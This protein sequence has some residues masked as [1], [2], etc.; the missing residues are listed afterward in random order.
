MMDDRRAEIGAIIREYDAQGWHR[1]GT[2]VDEASAQW[3]ADRVTSLGATPAF[4]SFTFE[5]VDPLPGYV[6]IDG[7]REEGTPA[8]D[9]TFTGGEGISG[10]IGPV[11]SDAEIALVPTPPGPERFGELYAARRS[12]LHRA[13]VAPTMGGMPGLGLINAP[14]FREPF[15]PPVLE[16]SSEAA[17]WLAAAAARGAT[18]HMVAAATRQHAEA[19]NVTA[20]VRGRDTSLA[21]LVAMTP[22]SGWWACASERGGGIACWLEVLRASCADDLDRT[23][24]FVA[25]SGHE[26]GHLGLKSFLGARPSLTR[27]AFATIHLGANIGAS[28]STLQPTVNEA[29]LQHAAAA[30]QGI[31]APVE[32]VREIGRTRG[33]SKDIFERGGR[34]VSFVGT[35]P[36]FHLPTDRWPDALNFDQLTAYAAAVVQLVRVLGQT[37]ATVAALR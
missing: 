34:Y 12:A 4:E 29:S 36:Q 14:D 10:R 24:Q 20:T 28:G 23:I 27:E 6:E 15:G 35:N 16:V 19:L 31:D 8:F 25:T 2:P 9:G 7:Q 13:I 32:L 37:E 5:R 1:T 26:L 11:G 17:P 3:L 30:L 22:R 33:E 21:P 18:V